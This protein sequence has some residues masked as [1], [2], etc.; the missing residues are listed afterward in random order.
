M[1]EIIKMNISCNKR[2]KT[3]KCSEKQAE[4]A[5][6]FIDVAWFWTVKNILLMTVQ[7]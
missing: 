6:N 7:T 2:E 1:L 5:K 3:P 4:K